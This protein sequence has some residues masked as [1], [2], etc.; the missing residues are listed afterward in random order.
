MNA[1]FVATAESVQTG[2]GGGM[3]PGPAASTAK[4]TLACIALKGVS[5]VSEFPN[6]GSNVMALTLHG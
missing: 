2:V 6:R 5:N 3:F 4:R 1:A